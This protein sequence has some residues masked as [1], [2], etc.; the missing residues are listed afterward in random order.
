VVRKK[1]V[2]GLLLF[3]QNMEEIV[4]KKEIFVSR[5]DM[6]KFDIPEGKFNSDWFV[7]ERCGYKVMK[8]VLGDVAT[9][10]EC[11]GT[12]HRIK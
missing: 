1:R 6:K 4:M 5:I 7:C 8:R 2:I 12:Q 9:C 10:S 3:V 11:G